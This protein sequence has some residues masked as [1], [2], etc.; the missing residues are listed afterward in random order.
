MKLQNFY[1]YKKGTSYMIQCRICKGY[2]KQQT[3]RDLHTTFWYCPIC[4]GERLYLDDILLT[5][6]ACK[7]PRTIQLTE[8]VYQTLY[9]LADGQD[10]L[11]SQ[12]IDRLVNR[13]P[14]M[15]LDGDWQNVPGQS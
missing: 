14:A 10:S 7:N 13:Q 8:T 15:Y 11:I 12:V 5:P 1:V 3:D 6:I 2:C 4:K 9:A